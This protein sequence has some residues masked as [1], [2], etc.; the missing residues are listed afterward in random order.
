M[1]PLSKYTTLNTVIEVHFISKLYRFKR[2]CWVR[3]IFQ[4]L[5]SFSVDS[6][7]HGTQLN[8]PILKNIS[9][10]S[11][12]V[13]E[14]SKSPETWEDFLLSKNLWLGLGE[15]VYHSLTNPFEVSASNPYIIVS[16]ALLA[17]TFYFPG[18]PSNLGRFVNNLS[19]GEGDDTNTM[20][21]DTPVITINGVTFSKEETESLTLAEAI[22]IFEG[23]PHC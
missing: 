19:G 15:T 12:V 3:T 16:L 10:G 17:Y 21:G 7:D 4:S 23:G 9:H 14:K 1:S 11:K 6:G 22:S 2:C 13:W 8:P 20:P 18:W 5:K